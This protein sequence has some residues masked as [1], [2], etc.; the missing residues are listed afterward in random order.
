MAKFLTRQQFWRE[1]N[2]LA[3]SQRRLF[4]AAWRAIN[5]SLDA[6]RGLPA[7]PL[8]QK[9]TDYDIFEV[10]WAA[11]GRATFHLEYDDQGMPIIVWRRIG[12]HSILKQ[13]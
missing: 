13:P 4:E 12:N 9:I 2:K 7:P 1:W 6:G 8:V 5:A 3:P 11:D 10:R